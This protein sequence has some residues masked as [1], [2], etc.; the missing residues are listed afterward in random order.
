ME[1]A[2]SHLTINPKE[3]ARKQERNWIRRLMAS[4]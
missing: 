4:I 1:E 2:S 3:M